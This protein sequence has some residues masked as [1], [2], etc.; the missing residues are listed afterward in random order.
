MEKRNG[1]TVSVIVPVYNGERYLARCMGSILGQTWKDLEILLIDDGSADGSG[2]LC[3]DFAEKYEKV[4]A[5]HTVNRGVSSARNLGLEEAAGDYVTFVDADDR[6]AEDMV[7]H[8]IDVL[9]KTGCDIAGCDFW[10]DRPGSQNGME[11]HN[12]RGRGSQAFLQQ[13]EALSGLEFMEKGIL[14]SDTRCWSKLYRKESI[15]DIRFDRELTIGEDMLFLLELA[16]AGRIFGR[17]GYQGYGYFINDEG[18]MMHPFRDS[19]MDQISCWERA[20]PV[21]A[22]ASPKLKDKAESILLV[23]VM[24]VAGKMAELPHRERKEKKAF[25]ERCLRLVREYGR[26]KGAF[27]NLD[28]GYQVKTAVYRRMPRIY[29]MLYHVVK[30]GRK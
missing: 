28:R 16:R 26:H 17:S 22:E 21:L 29:M 10:I 2:R 24:L 8:L 13:A 12:R 14:G 30:R 1:K 11:E 7:E 6:L 18:A 25:E 27:G 4:R 23:S 3:D 9:E 15:G 20:L 19:Y 5:V